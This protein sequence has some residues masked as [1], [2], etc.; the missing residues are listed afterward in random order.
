VL[1]APGRAIVI[2]GSRSQSLTIPYGRNA[3]GSSPS[4]VV[5]DVDKW[6][7]SAPVLPAYFHGQREAAVQRAVDAA[8]GVAGDFRGAARLNMDIGPEPARMM[9]GRTRR[10]GQDQRSSGR[11]TT[12]GVAVLRTTT[13]SNG[14]SADGLISM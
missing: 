3:T 2:S 6:A 5:F 8:R 7:G 1:S 10:G 12:I 13:H 14:V 4:S 11:F 9:R